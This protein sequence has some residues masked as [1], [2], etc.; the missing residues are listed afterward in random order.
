MDEA[1]AP[2]RTAPSGPSPTKDP[3]FSDLKRMTFLQLPTDERPEQ[4]SLCLQVLSF[5][6]E[7]LSWTL[8]P[9]VARDERVI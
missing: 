4:D 3:V 8:T 2:R 1:L 6:D 5:R 9:A 7:R